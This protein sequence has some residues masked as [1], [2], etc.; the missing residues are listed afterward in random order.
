MCRSCSASSASAAQ[1]EASRAELKACR[2]AGEQ[3]L[4]EWRYEDARVAFEQC[5]PL[6]SGDAKNDSSTA[7][8]RLNR[9]LRL[10]RIIK[11]NRLLRLAK[12]SRNLKALERSP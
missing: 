5:R 11:L 2:A 12:L 4:R 8:G 7:A 1:A 10:L 9:Q 6:A 3:A